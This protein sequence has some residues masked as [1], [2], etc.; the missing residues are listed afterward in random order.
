MRRLD[1]EVVYIY[2]KAGIGKTR[3]VMDKYGDE[4][5][6]RITDYDGKLFDNYNNEDI[7]IFEEFRGQVRIDIMLNY[8]DVYPLRLP[9]KY[10]N[11]IA[12]FTKIFLIT[13]LPLSAQYK[14]VQMNTPK[15]G[16]PFC[17]V[18]TMFITLI[19]P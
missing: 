7:I 8:L 14:N 5:V 15:L 11:K 16:K 4:N 13:N 12:W 2:G 18:Y 1:L 6:Y 10:K 19:K 17:D 9:A 3:Y